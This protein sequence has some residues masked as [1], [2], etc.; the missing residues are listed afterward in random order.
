MPF[1]LVHQP[2]ILLIAYHVVDRNAGVWT[3]YALLMP[4]ALSTSAVPA[5]LL[6]VLP[7]VSTL[8]GVEQPNTASVPGRRRVE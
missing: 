5:W 4:A 1:L 3:K 6:S 7:G 8:F 2:L